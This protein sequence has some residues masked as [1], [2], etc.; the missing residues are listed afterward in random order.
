MNRILIWDWPVR[1]GHWLLVAAFALAWLTGESETFRLLHA[2]AGGAL[3]G[4]IGFRIVWGLVGTW[5]A[6]FASFVRGPRAV[7]A[8][9]AGLLHRRHDDAAYAGHNAAGGWAIVG[10]LLLGLLTGATGW[11]TYQELGG[12]WME[13]AHEVAASAM[14][15]LAG[16]PVAGVVVS[17]LAHG[18]NLVR[19]MFTGM[20]RGRAD[21]AIA[22]ARAWAVPILLACAAA[23]AVWFAQ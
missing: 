15:A 5:H 1:V 4:I 9:V 6:R 23:G 10:L 20:K 14:L 19:A 16:V 13:E 21:E 8:Y 12:E 18:E 3:I 7:F 2:W 17:S 22:S 11:A